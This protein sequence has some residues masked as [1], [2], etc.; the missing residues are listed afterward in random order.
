MTRLELIVLSERRFGRLAAYECTLH[1]SSLVALNA[2]FWLAS[3]SAPSWASLA[4][5]GLSAAL[6][7]IWSRVLDAS[8]R[9][10]AL[11]MADDWAE[12]ERIVGE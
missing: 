7:A 3:A 6:R 10:H 2:G 1:Y 11:V 5:W 8:E 9:Q 4:C 12:L